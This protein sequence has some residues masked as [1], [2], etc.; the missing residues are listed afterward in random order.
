MASG[1]KTEAADE[2]LT[3]VRDQFT[4]SVT[5][6]HDELTEAE[7]ARAYYD[8]HQWTQEEKAKLKLRGQAATVDNLI[9]DKVE[10]MLG[11]ERKT[12]T[13][14]LCNPRNLDTDEQ[15]AQAATDALRYVCDDNDFNQVRSEYSECI[16]IEA[17]GAVEIWVDKKAKG[18]VPKIVVAEVQRDRVYV[19]PLSRRRDYADKR[20]CGIVV[21]FDEKD[22][23]EKWPEKKDAIDASFDQSFIDRDFYQDRPY[24]FGETKGR[25][26][27]RVQVMQHFYIRQ[28]QWWTCKFVAGGF[29]EEPMVSPYIDADTGLPECQL[30]LQAL[31]REKKSGRAYSL[32]RRY[33]DLQDEWNKRRS[34]ALHLLNTNRLITEKGAA[35]ADPGAIDKVREEM[36][37]PDGVVE[38][39]P[40]MKFQIVDG[41]QL[42]QAHVNLMMLTGESLRRS[43]PNSAL[44]GNSGDLSGRAKELDQQGGLINVDYPFDSIRSLTHRVYRQIW[45][46]VKQ[47]WT[48][49]A[50]IRVRDGDQLKFTALNRKVTRAEMIASYLKT[51]EDMSEEEKAQVLQVVAQDPIYL[52][53]V[54]LNS[55]AEI[56]VDIT[57]DEV[58]DVV[59]IQHEEYS[60]LIDLVKA[61]AIQVP[62][63]TIIKMGQFRNKREILADLT[64][65]DDPMQQQMTALQLK[66]SQLQA[67]KLEAE[68]RNIMSQVQKNQAT[69][70]E[71]NVDAS[72]KLA[73]FM[74]PQAAGKAKTSVLVN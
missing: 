58:P 44:T 23:L 73:E 71:T 25:K 49:E 42:S 55:T 24:F 20:Y 33:K 63:K 13:D 7:E 18:P 26:R 31:Y 46:R 22:A 8:G 62:A 16:F 34:K 54:T 64:G 9:K 41:I 14:P 43:G 52:E 12:R 37:R 45:N 1:V 4:D 2:I 36:G 30:E 66:V 69:V 39:V 40:G 50:W 27:R 29:L 67:M 65:A 47:F 21:W 74:S 10:W 6:S 68:I 57:I 28:G 72:V 15:Q 3:L 51:V 5:G 70:A 35:G 32:N 11:M 17:I 48:E 19:D 60:K 53:Q 56:D 61:R 38:L 59:N